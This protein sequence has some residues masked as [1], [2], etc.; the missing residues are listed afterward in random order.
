MH[1]S[2][3]C[4]CRSRPRSS[5]RTGTRRSAWPGVQIALASN[6]PFLLGKALWH[7]TRIPLFQQ[8]TDTRPEELQEP[9]R[10]AAGL[11]RRALDHVDLRPV[12]GERPLLPRP[13]PG[14][15][16]RGPDR[17]ALDAGR[18]TEA[19]RAAHA[20]RHDLAVEP[21]GVRRRRRPAAPARG[22]PRAAR[23]TDR[24]R[25]GGER[26]VLLRRAA[27]AGR[28]RNVQC[29]ARCRSR[30]PR[31]TCTRARGTASARSCTGRASAG[32]RR[33]SW[34]C[35]CCCPGPR[36]PARAAASPTTC[37]RALPRD[38]R[39]AVR[40]AAH[41]LV[42]AARHGARPW[43]DA[44]S[45]GRRRVAAML[46]AT[47]SCRESGDARAHLAGRRLTRRRRGGTPTDKPP[48]TN[49]VRPRHR[50]PGAGAA[51]FREL[52]AAPTTKRIEVRL[53]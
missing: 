45:T 19:R 2:C 41:R 48:R 30:R 36:G 28:R 53:A 4:T 50:S 51:R 52:T 34:C 17:A 32:C 35:A 11:V 37:P 47:S 31:R 6:S 29:G 10:A 33:T 7:E 43:S 42:V 27:G 26:R 39:A 22:E 49:A 20:Q 23:R 3:S 15:R 14:H 5:P 46:A 25:P 40:R 8:A 16:R 12:R 13:A 1:Q 38:H 44:G 18:R 9:G 21:P 24:G